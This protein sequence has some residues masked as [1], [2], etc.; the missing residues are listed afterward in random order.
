MNGIFTGSQHR[1]KNKKKS[2]GKT[3][4]WKKVISAMAP[5]K[6][7]FGK[8]VILTIL[9]ILSAAGSIYQAITEKLPLFV[10]IAVYAC[11]AVCLT[12]CSICYIFKFRYVKN[13]VVKP[14]IA[15]H[16]LLNRLVKDVKLRTVLTALPGM[17]VNLI[18]AIFNGII[19]ITAKSAWYGSLSAYYFIL[20]MMRFLAA[21]YAQKI[22]FKKAL[23]EESAQREKKVYR[24]CGRLLIV[25]SIALGGAVIMLVHGEGGKTYPGLIIYAVAFYTFYKLILSVVNMVKANK[26]KSYLLMT[27]RNI[28]YADALVSMLSLQTALLAEFG[29]QTEFPVSIVNGL[30]GTAVCV[31]ILLIGS[32]MTWKD[33]KFKI[34]RDKMAG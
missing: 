13:E 2:D 10:G 11:A 15:N 19:G 3:N 34:A 30:T 4:N 21:S 24:N 23:E 31:M 25:T 18:F 26:A 22:Y 29:G 28:G 6:L 20:C 12:F 33:E 1:L 16:R 17:G 5:Q 8:I 9:T 32:Y 14:Y 7:T 27:L